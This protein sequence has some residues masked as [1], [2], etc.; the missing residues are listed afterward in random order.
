MFTGLDG[1]VLVLHDGFG[2]GLDGCQ[3]T[4]FPRVVD[5]YGIYFPDSACGKIV[6]AAFCFLIEFRSGYLQLHNPAGGVDSRD[7]EVAEFA[8]GP[9]E[10]RI[11]LDV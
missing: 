3:R 7:F 1:D 11:D 9:R 4:V 5:G 10:V 8:C 6:L 2:V